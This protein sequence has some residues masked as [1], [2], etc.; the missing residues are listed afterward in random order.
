MRIV[1]NE[2]KS[3]KNQ[4]KNAKDR[5]FENRQ[6]FLPIQQRIRHFHAND[7]S[8]SLAPNHARL[9]NADGVSRSPMGNLRTSLWRLAL[10]VDDLDVACALVRL[11][12]AL[13]AHLSHAAIRAL[14]RHLVGVECDLAQSS[15]AAVVPIGFVYDG[16]G[17]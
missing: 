4:S 12:G 13:T 5:D 14:V 11:E 8:F 10:S 2:S 3:T 9:S 1:Q 7:A 16:D 15:G 6:L 17:A